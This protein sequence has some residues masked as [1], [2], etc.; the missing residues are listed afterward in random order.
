MHPQE[1]PYSLRYAATEPQVVDMN[2]D[3]LLMYLDDGIL[4]SIMEDLDEVQRREAELI[5]RNE[6]LA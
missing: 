6:E 2:L 5:R 4:H 1:I 3:D